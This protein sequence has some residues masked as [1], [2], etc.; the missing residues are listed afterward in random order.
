MPASRRAWR[1]CT[2][3]EGH[4]GTYTYRLEPSLSNRMRR[5]PCC[6]SPCMRCLGR[7]SGTY[8]YQL[9]LY[10]ENNLLC[11]G[12][13]GKGRHFGRHGQ[14]RRLGPRRQSSPGRLH[15]SFSF[16][17]TSRFVCFVGCCMCVQYLCQWRWKG[18]IALD[19]HFVLKHL[20]HSER[21]LHFKEGLN[22]YV[23]T[24]NDE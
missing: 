19:E 24:V 23:S 15:E 20:R 10:K 1:R 9:L 2:G 18:M 22:R 11:I 8:S 5:S 7:T 14:Q 16:C 17:F 13:K 3:P 21:P 6:S 12:R 4:P